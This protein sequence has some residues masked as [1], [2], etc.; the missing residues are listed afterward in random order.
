MRTRV[1][2]VLSTRKVAEPKQCNV[3]AEHHGS[4]GMYH[5]ERATPSA[6]RASTEHGLELI[7]FE[8]LALDERVRQR[9]EFCAVLHDQ[10]RCRRE[11][12]VE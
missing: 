3:H 2:T 12:I 6:H 7:A 1:I 4:T 5:V 8:R 11:R 10:L 9:V